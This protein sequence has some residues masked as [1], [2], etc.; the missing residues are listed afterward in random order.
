MVAFIWM[1]LAVVGFVVAAL[2]NDQHLG[3]LAL[4]CAATASILAA[5]DTPDDS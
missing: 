2:T 1:I 4:I 5:L 3:I